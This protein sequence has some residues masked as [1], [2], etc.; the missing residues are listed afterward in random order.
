[1]FNEFYK[2]SINFKELKTHKLIFENPFLLEIKK[3]DIKY[4]FLIRLKKNSNKLIVLGS[5]AYQKSTGKLPLFH[6]H[7][8]IPEFNESVIFYNDPTLYLGHLSLGWGFGTSKKHFLSEISII[9]KDIV[10]KLKY[11]YENVYYYGSSAGGFMSL[12]LASMMKGST[13]IVN[14]PQTILINY[15]QN[16][17]NSL[18]KVVG[19]S[20]DE[21][22]NNFYDRI[23]VTYRFKKENYIPKI[24]YLQNILVEHDV[25]NHLQPFLNGLITTDKDIINNRIHIELY[26]DP[27]R[28]HNPVSK[29]ETIQFIEKVMYNENK[30]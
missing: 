9:I 5:G 12:M 2:I 25:I 3:N 15:H 30:P 1:M 4:E 14:N 16:Y 18:L 6:R 26:F 7:S 28:G 11:D 22:I 13:A 17:V 27:K 23:D 19:I 20:K 10:E 21:A 24:Y 8:W 29:S